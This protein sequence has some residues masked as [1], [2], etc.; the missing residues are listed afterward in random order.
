MNRLVL[1]LT[2]GLSAAGFA[3][4]LLEEDTD[5]P[6]NDIR[7]ID[8]EEEK[9]ELCRA[10]CMKEP[11]CN[12]FTYVR[13]MHQGDH[14]RCFLKTVAPAPILKGCCVSGLRS[15]LPVGMEEH[16]D[17]PGSD[18][19]GFDLA[20]PRPELCRDA[21][22]A[23]PACKAYTYVRPAG[24]G[25]SPRCYLK[26][27]VPSAMP[28]LCC[29]SGVKSQ[30]PAGMEEYTD[31]PGNDWKG[32]DLPASR[33]ELCRA[34]CDAASA[35]KAYTYVKPGLHAPGARCYLKQGV[36]EPKPSLCC[37]SGVKPPLP[38]GMV[39]NTDRP[40]ADLKAFNLEEPRPELC[41][42]ACAEEPACK[43]FTYMRPDVQGPRARCFL[44]AQVLEPKPNTCCA[45]G[46]KGKPTPT[47]A[48]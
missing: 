2:L 33:P 15:P 17:R 39:E 23:Q 29:V 8:L 38:V 22:N 35:C 37:V 16:T 3:Q 7:R 19:K 43:A 47:P 25:S 31:R 44:K 32:F 21:C 10:A 45:S 14:P 11:A 36:P 27:E 13:P 48:R 42:A 26:S 12:A 20:A 24:Q 40:G 28:D 9:P 34:A 46:V 6:G 5:R 41:R 4:P 18:L 30:L 1:V